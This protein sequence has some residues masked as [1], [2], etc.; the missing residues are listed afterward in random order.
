MA[1]NMSLFIIDRAETYA[2][3]GGSNTE[4][5]AKCELHVAREPVNDQTLLYFKNSLCLQHLK[6]KIIIPLPRIYLFLLNVVLI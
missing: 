3:P 6:C 1:L 4:A 2:L 5:A